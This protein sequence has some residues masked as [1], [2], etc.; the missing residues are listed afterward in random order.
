MLKF[1]RLD[2]VLKTGA[3]CVLLLA[4]VGG[5]IVIAQKREAAKPTEYHQELVL[6]EQGLRIQAPAE[7]IQAYTDAYTRGESPEVLEKMLDEIRS[8]PN[9]V[10]I[11]L[12]DDGEPVDSPSE[13]DIIQAEAVL[14]E[15]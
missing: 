12:Q 13:E 7:V 15:N 11:E 14:E 4:V 5:G 8:D 2:N 3:A 9:N 10:V 6:L 1:I